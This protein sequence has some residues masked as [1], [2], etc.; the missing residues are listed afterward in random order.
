M[1]R[2]LQPEADIQQAFTALVREHGRSIYGHIR[3]LVPHCADADDVFQET[4]RTLWEKFDQYH[5]N[6]DFRAW[7]CRI[8]YYKVLQYRGRIFRSKLVFSPELLDLLGEE[9]VVMSD[10][11]DVRREALSR[12]RDKLI[13]RHQDLLERYYRDGATVRRIASH[14]NRS[15]DYVY[16][17]VR[18]IHDLLHDCVTKTIRE[19]R[20]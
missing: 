10:Q 7:A 2:S 16:R 3:T 13:P 12:C 17:T 15:V 9:A 19:E 11:L 8:A 18:Q 4:S 5:C 6:T 20:E 1:S 14:L